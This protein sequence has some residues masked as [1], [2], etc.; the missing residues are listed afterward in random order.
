[1]SDT[2]LHA[3]AGPDTTEAGRDTRWELPDPVG[4]GRRRAGRRTLAAAALG[5]LVAGGALAAPPVEL[6]Q[7]AAVSFDAEA[8]HLTVEGFD[9][10][11]VY[12]LRYVHGDEAEVRVPVRNDGWLST[13][14]TSVSFDGRPA[15]MIDPIGTDGT[16]VELSP[17]EEATLTVRVRFDNCEYYTE[18]AMDVYEAVTVTSRTA[19]I[20]SST[21]VVLD[22]ALVVR[23]P[24]MTTCPDRVSDRGAFL[25]GG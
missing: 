22:H 11:G 17:G 12:S 20:A 18:R 23:S 1:M 13:T 4:R 21:P 7:A 8:T 16:P 2:L 24:M 14:V 19:G 3:D 15:P 6:A 25:R 10:R 9:D 5:S